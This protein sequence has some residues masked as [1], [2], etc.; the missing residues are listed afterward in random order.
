MASHTS[1]DG[2]LS[3]VAN[4]FV[5]WHY[6]ELEDGRMMRR[7][8][9][10]VLSIICNI[11]IVGM[12]VLLP[13]KSATASD[14]MS[15]KEDVMSFRWEGVNWVIPK[16]FFLGFRPY[17]GDNKDMWIQFGY[18]ISSANLIPANQVGYDL[19]MD[20]HIRRINTE[21]PKNAI[22]M[23]GRV[24]I[25]FEKLPLFDT[26]KF[27][28]MTYVG[29][30]ALGPYFRMSQNEAY[31]GCHEVVHDRLVFPNISLGALNEKYVCGTT[32]KMPNGLYAWVVV[33]GV[34]LNDVAKLFTT[35]YNLVNSFI[36]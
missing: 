5:Y 12:S 15:N 34:H 31:V 22:S 25:E 19:R 20:V 8:K 7:P 1:R 27:N 17:S 18:V 32:F 23:I 29:S 30:S 28:G 3:A 4:Q 10:M 21:D 9:K 2:R 33:D 14:V 35:T 36:H 26:A 24:G 6:I 13:P 16:K 11:F